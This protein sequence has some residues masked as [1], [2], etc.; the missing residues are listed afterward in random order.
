MFIILDSIVNMILMSRIYIKDLGIM[1]KIDMDM[2][3]SC[4][5][6]TLLACFAAS[7]NRSRSSSDHFKL[8]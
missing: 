6:L 2:I 3:W 8:V 4:P 7:E 5:H 1:K